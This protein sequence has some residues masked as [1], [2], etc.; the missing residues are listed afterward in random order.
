MFGVLY[1]TLYIRYPKMSAWDVP[2]ML[3]TES[4]RNT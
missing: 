2:T 3:L 1:F 4:Q